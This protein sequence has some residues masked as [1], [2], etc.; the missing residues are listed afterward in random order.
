MLTYTPADHQQK[1]GYHEYPWILLLLV[2]AWLWPGVFSHDLWRPSEPS[3]F[4]VLRENSF[5]QLWQPTLLG[6]AYFDTPPLYL[7]TASL[8]HQL[9]SPWL[10]DEFAAARFA[11]VFFTT[12]GFIACGIASRKFWGKHYGRGSVLILIGSLGLWSMGHFLNGHS[13]LFAGVSLCLWA[14]AAVQRQVIF[15]ALLLAV[16]I[17]FTAHSAGWLFACLPIFT[18]PILYFISPLWRQKRHLLV[19]L[20]ASVIWI[21]IATSVV[22]FNAK[23]APDFLQ[24]YLNHHLFGHFGGLHHFQMA[25]NLPYYSLNLLWFTFPALPLAA[26]TA[27]RIRLHQHTAGILALFWL[28]TGFILL[29]LSPTPHQDQLIFLLPLLALLGTAQLD[30]LRRGVAAFFNWF[31]IMIAGT[32]AL[33]LWL[34]FFAMNFGFPAKLAERAA[35]FSPY[36]TPEIKW[37]P[38]LIAVSFTPIW[39]FAVTRSHIRGRQAVTNW[40]AGITLIWALLMTLFLP[41]LDAAKSYRPIVQSMEK[42]LNPTDLNALTQSCLYINPQHKTAVLA[43]QEYSHFTVSLNSQNSNCAYTIQ[44]THVQQENTTE[45][46]LWQGKRPRNKHEQFQLLHNQP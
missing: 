28:I 42:S 5:M 33:F 22:L 41:W 23:Y 6:Q 12:I 43:W 9:L 18:L 31:G 24:H 16:G 10:M 1:T 29:S 26:W 11:S 32:A 2:F 15:A 35:Y 13:V 40:A 4:A 25:F 34:G 3:I 46:I 37:M 17:L 45:Q 7:Q 8:F 21:P 19:C 38:V 14:F 44:Q 27:Y 39:L 20:A 36:Y 30:Q